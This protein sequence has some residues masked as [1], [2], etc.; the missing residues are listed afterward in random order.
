MAPPHGTAA[1]PPRLGGL[2][3]NFAPPVNMPN[4]NFSAPIIRLGTA[5]PSK[6]SPISA[7]GRVG[8]SEPFGAGRRGLGMDRGGMDHS[9]QQRM[10]QMSLIPPTREEVMRTIFVGKISPAITDNDLERILRAAGSLRRW[11][12]AYDVNNK[13]CTFGFAEY[14]DAES[15]E[16]AAEVLPDVEVPAKKPEKPEA[17][18]EAKGEENGEENGASK[19]VEKFKL[20]VRMPSITWTCNANMS[21]RSKLMRPQ[22]NMLKNGERSGERMNPHFSSESTLQT[23]RWAKFLPACS[24]H[25]LPCRQTEMS[26]WK[27]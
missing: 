14:E 10:E 5:G 6:D 21:A 13:P 22:R 27:T 1:L 23:K 17:K 16:T 24:T 26:R 25:P 12:R 8:N 3:P 4:I 11:T 19:K 9:R 20:L 2:P 15:L 18:S 7:G